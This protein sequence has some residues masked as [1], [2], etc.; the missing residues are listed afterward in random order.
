[1]KFIKNHSYPCILILLIL[2]IL[3][4]LINFHTQ[5][6]DYTN[7]LSAMMGALVGSMGPYVIGLQSQKNEY[8]KAKRIFT[9]LLQYTHSV[10]N[11][12]NVEE[13]L[14][15][16]LEN[17]AIGKVIYDDQWSNYLSFLDRD[18]SDDEINII[19]QWFDRIFI[20]ENSD[21]DRYVY[22]ATL[23]DLQKKSEDIEAI[24]K[25]LKTISIS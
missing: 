23:T 12:E 7:V 24:I 16:P 14:K 3:L 11:D 19:V 21:I 20:L 2:C 4:T 10:F 8:K 17:T 18:L 6:S 9:R 22:K 5:L 1:M 15:T 25:K 13:Y